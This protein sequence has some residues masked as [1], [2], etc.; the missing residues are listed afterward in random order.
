MITP[1]YPRSG[2]L[3]KS[4]GESGLLDSENPNAC[5]GRPC[6]QRP[7]FPLFSGHFC[8]HPSPSL[9]CCYAS[10]YWAGYWPVIGRLLGS[11]AR[12][13]GGDRRG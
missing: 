5:A 2:M 6:I 12:F 3:E 4:F 13:L 1:V 7:A 8:H 9:T 11:Q 10:G